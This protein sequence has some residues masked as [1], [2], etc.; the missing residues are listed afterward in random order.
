M[1]WPGTAAVVDGLVIFGARQGLAAFRESSGERVWTSQMWTRPVSAFAKNIALGDGRACIADQWTIGCIQISDGHVL[2]T[3]EPDSLSGDGQS[4]YS[5]GTWFYGARDHKVRAVDPSSGNVRWATDITPEAQFLTRIFGVVVRGDTVI[6]TTVRWV[7]RSS[8]PVKGDVVAL[9]NTTGSILWRYTTPGDRGGFQGKA[10]LTDRLVIV[11]DAYAHSLLG[12]DLKTGVEVWRTTNDQLGYINS[13]TTPVLVGDTVFAGSTDTQVYA[14]DAK[15]GVIL[16]RVVGDQNGLGSV[17][18]CP[19]FLIPLEFAGGKPFLV[20]RGTHEV[21]PTNAAGE[22]NIITSRFGV[23]GD[24][25]YAD[26]SGGV[27]AF[28][29]N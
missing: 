9:D 3:S 27:Y 7:T 8:L 4:D 5:Q 6:A 15:T 25:A 14:V 22:G 13:E 1:G 23:A 11:N 24:M 20:D 16:W 26:G 12:I 21:I 18:V 2:W 17:D 19:H 10:L 29:C 28:R